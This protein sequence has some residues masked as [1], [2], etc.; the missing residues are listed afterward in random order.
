MHERDGLRNQMAVSCS[1]QHGR[2]ETNTVRRA[3]AGG[4]TTELSP[5]RA[6]TN[7]DRPLR[8]ADDDAAMGQI[9]GLIDTSE[10][11]TLVLTYFGWTR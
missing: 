5:Q 9:C 10:S 7:S 3:L 8:V 4:G 2:V 1:H 11:A 6:T